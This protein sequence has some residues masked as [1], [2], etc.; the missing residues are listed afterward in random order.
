[1]VTAFLGLGSN[2]GNR[3]ALLQSGRARL[4][5]AQG[6]VLEGCSALYETAAEGCPPEEAPDGLV[7]GD[8]GE[9]LADHGVP[10]RR[11]GSSSAWMAGPTSATTSSSVADASGS[12][13]SR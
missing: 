2:L 11:V 7:A 12:I 8:G 4:A 1:M 5:A 10:G 6:V 9:G 3:R 13:R